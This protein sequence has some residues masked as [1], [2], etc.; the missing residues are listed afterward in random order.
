M[1]VYLLNTTT[2][3]A[4]KTSGNKAGAIDYFGHT[5]QWKTGF[6]QPHYLSA[7]SGIS[8]QI[9]DFFISVNTKL[10]PI[11]RP[12]WRVADA[13]W[14]HWTVARYHASGARRAWYYRRTYWHMIMSASFSLPALFIYYEH[15]IND[16]LHMRQCHAMRLRWRPRE[17]QTARRDVAFH[18][19]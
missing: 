2:L 3:I 11:D 16:D 6:Q 14:S 13:L 18:A 15:E 17:I 9:H 12:L 7:Q 19:I 5:W 10:L 1:S 8:L 4:V